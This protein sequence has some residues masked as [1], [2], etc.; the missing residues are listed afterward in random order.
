LL[1]EFASILDFGI[2]P[3]LCSVLPISNQ[4]I[5]IGN[6]LNCINNCTQKYTENNIGFIPKSKMDSNSINKQPS[7]SYSNLYK[8]QARNNLKNTGYYS[9]SNSSNHS[10]M[11]NENHIS[12]KVSNS[13]GDENNNTTLRNQSSTSRT[14]SNDRDYLPHQNSHNLMTTSRQIASR[15]SNYIHSHNQMSQIS[16]NTNSSTS[17]D[18]SFDESFYKSGYNRNIVDVP[19]WQEPDYTE[20][21][22]SNP[23]N[24]QESRSK[25]E[26]LSSTLEFLKYKD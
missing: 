18:R 22:D 19:M 23:I 6:L 24:Y 1:I 21:A 5:T 2:K 8:K 16:P 25:Q 20:L 3:I 10:G 15:S 9:S 4:N 17:F 11:S 12:V 13:S 26:A 14:S 7:N